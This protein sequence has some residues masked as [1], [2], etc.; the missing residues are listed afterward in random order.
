MVP[1]ELYFTRTVTEQMGGGR[2]LE[3]QEDQKFLFV[4]V[5]FLVQS[6]PK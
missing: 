3:Q 6:K 5:T 4:G 1:K 2:L